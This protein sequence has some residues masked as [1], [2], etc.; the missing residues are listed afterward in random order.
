MANQPL[1]WAHR[2]ASGHAPENSLEAFDLAFRLGADGLELDVQL[3]ADGRVV[4]CHDETIDRTSNGV[5]AIAE[6]TYAELAAFDYANDQTGFSNIMLPTL[7][8]VFA[9]LDDTEMVINIEL[10]NSI[11][12]YPGLE[13]AVVEL[14]HR[15]SWDHR[16][17]L[18]S[19]NHLSVARLQGSG[20]RTA[21]LYSEPLYE[22]WVHAE[23]VGATAVH[24]SGHALRIDPG[25]VAECRERGIDVNVWT[26][27]TPEDARAAAD[28]GVH[29]IITNYPEI[30][31]HLAV[32]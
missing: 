22:P 30:R 15:A 10:K 9:L 2:G 14:V 5:G 7:E 18:S 19:F 6:M 4:V 28:L 16:V 31:S 1:I 17:V 24:P 8:Q 12:P 27:N 29:A 3:S 32:R 21:I 23:R 20:L 11:E 26:I 13:D 25:S